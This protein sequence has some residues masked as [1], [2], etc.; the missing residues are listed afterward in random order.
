MRVDKYTTKSG[1]KSARQWNAVKSFALIRVDV[2]PTLNPGLV[3]LWFS[4]WILTSIAKE[5]YSFVILQGGPDTPATAPP[6]NP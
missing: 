4:Q 3:A 2:G 1:P 5:A 6:W